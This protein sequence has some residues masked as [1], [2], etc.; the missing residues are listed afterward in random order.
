MTLFRKLV[1]SLSLF[2]LLPIIF[3]GV[4]NYSNTVTVLKAGAISEL[5]SISEIQG[6]KLEAAH[7]SVVSALAHLAENDDLHA[8]L[9]DLFSEAPTTTA[10]A[11]ALF[12]RELGTLNPSLVALLHSADGSLIASSSPVSFNAAASSTSTQAIIRKSDEGSHYIVQSR[13]LGD[14]SLQVQSNID[15]LLLHGDALYFGRSGEVTLLSQQPPLESTT[16]TAKRPSQKE[17]TGKVFRVQYAL[18]S[19]GATVVASK[20]LEEIISPARG[21]L[22]QMAGLAVLMALIALGM[23]LVFSRRIHAPLTALAEIAEQIDNGHMDRRLPESAPSQELVTLA[24]TFNKIM[25]RLCGYNATLEEAVAERTRELE[26][27]RV[28]AEEKSRVQSDFLAN[29]SHEIRTPMNGILGIS[30]LLGNTPLDARQQEYLNIIRRSARSLLVILND[31]LDLSKM[32]AGKLFINPARFNL[33][34]LTKDLIEEAKAAVSERP[35]T[36]TR[37]NQGPVPDWVVADPVRIKQ[38]LNNLL[39]NAVKFT[40]RGSVTL[41][42]SYTRINDDQ[43]D[44]QFCVADTGIGIPLK[45]Q[46]SIFEAFSQ[47]DNSTTR[48]FGGTGLGLTIVAKLSELMKGRVWLESQVSKGSRFFV[49]I[50]VQANA[51]I[52]DNPKAT[53][54][55]AP[56]DASDELFNSRILQSSTN[57]DDLAP[58]PLSILVAE[59]NKTNQRVLLDLLSAR[60]HHLTVV[61]NGL[62]AVQAF[63]NGHYDQIL[64]DV[65]MPVMDGFEAA[66]K[67][68]EIEG[69]TGHPI[70]IVALTAHALRGD[71]Q[72]CFSAGMSDYL[73]KPID[74]AQLINKIEGGTMDYV[75]ETTRAQRPANEETGRNNM[76]LDKS[77]LID[78]TRNNTA[79]MRS[80][81]QLFLD[82]L[83]EM[84]SGIED[85][86]KEGDPQ[87]LSQ[88]IHRLKSALGNFVI[89]DYYKEIAHLE[90]LAISAPTQQ[91]QESWH[92]SQLRLN[93]LITELKEATGL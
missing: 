30:T 56:Q 74:P 78:I 12:Q 88:A 25:D 63:R 26:E 4:L 50:P 87:A 22:V 54:N 23:A 6:H 58:V 28:R 81:A 85:A 65:Q 71:D 5:E 7:N 73:A 46:N 8:L 86:Q 68:R 33:S 55:S 52:G 57:L 47:A 18:P 79:L 14:G 91:W 36:V 13:P 39:A 80:I 24:T 31:I 67:I 70:P 61:D 45:K 38:I 27:A 60:G 9:P 15:H 40:E 43:G 29:M 32:R 42:V 62:A 19:L 49:A 83:P 72:R 89:S 90:S 66:E 34:E 16:S 53:T 92:D 17:E 77:R 37:K 69:K 75:S 21:Q 2:A 20:N 10:T 41:E 64:M 3:L 76:V 84:L 35:I 93:Q 44:L 11:I 1:L 51:H 82:E 48:R 59:D